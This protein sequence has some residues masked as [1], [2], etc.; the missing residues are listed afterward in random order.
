MK[1][2]RSKWLAVGL[3]VSVIVTAVFVARLDWTEFRATIANVKWSWVAGSA[4]AIV[5]S[6]TIRAARWLAI[7]GAK[8]GQLGAYWNSTIIGYVGNVLYPGRAGEVLRI[9]ALHHALRL[10]PGELMSKAVMDRMADVVF[11][12][13]AALYVAGVATRNIGTEALFASMVVII[14][15]PV[16][17]FVG[18]LMLGAH[19]KPLVSRL[20]SLL[21]GL[22]R[23]RVPRWYG[24]MLSACGE[25]TRPGRLGA[26]SVLTLFAYGVDYTSFW[27]FLRAFDWPLSMN[28]AM[29]TAVLVAVGSVLPA[30]P[31][32]IGI[33]QA[34]C[35]IGLGAYGIGESSALAF[36]VIAQ[37]STIVVIALLGAI[38]AARYGMGFGLAR[39][40][41]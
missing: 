27:L 40:S 23:E 4:L 39:R 15:V 2:R 34:A 12:G 5:L 6:I 25:M 21:P 7:S 22:W 41:E 14:V 32:N 13:L 30:A 36:S 1:G 37:G 28:V 35:V 20:A 29:T 8:P 10:P 9:A 31:G 11:L 19:L 26:A 16:V 18:F 24:Q 33:Y 3:A 17:A 38:V